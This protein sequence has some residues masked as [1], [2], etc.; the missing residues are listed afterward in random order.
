MGGYVQ[1][2]YKLI[3]YAKAAYNGTISEF[4]WI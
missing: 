4:P 3:F 1:L 2:Y